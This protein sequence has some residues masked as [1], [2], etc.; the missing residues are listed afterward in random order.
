MLSQ[1]VIN[2]KFQDMESATEGLHSTG[3]E[4]QQTAALLNTQTALTWATHSVS[5]FSV[6]FYDF[7]V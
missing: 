1:E 4:H 2:L 3:E 6:L 5:T 7:S